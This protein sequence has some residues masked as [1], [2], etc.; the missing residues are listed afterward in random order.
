[1]LISFAPLSFGLLYE[2]F[3]LFDLP[4]A[5]IVASKRAIIQRFET[6]KSHVHALSVV[7]N[8]SVPKARWNLL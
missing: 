6:I 5:L 8:S 1:M 4:L 3:G 7:L 2:A